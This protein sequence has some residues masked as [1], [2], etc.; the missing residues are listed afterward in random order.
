M[1]KSTKAEI[2]HRVDEVYDLLINRITY[3]AIL[4]YGASKWGVKERQMNV[5]IAR[6]RE[7]L[8]EL[9]KESEE[10]RLA[11]AIASYNSLY[12]RQVAEK[13]YKGARQTMDS[14]IRL[15]GLAGRDR[16]NL[17]SALGQ[18]GYVGLNLEEI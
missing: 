2:E 13:D 18:K 5:Y 3:Q 15:Q 7:R 14:L 8:K 4:G 9:N 10:E 16:K 17:E 6:A 1:P 11:T 12:A